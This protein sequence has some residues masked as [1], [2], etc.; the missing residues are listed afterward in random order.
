MLVASCKMVIHTKSLFCSV[1]KALRADCVCDIGSRDGDQALLFRHLL[2]AA[3]IMAFEA[4]PINFQTMSAKAVLN[5]NLIEIFPYAV[6]SQKGHAGFYVTDV[7]YSNPEEN[8]GTSSLLV[9]E[10][11]KVRQTVKVETVRIDEFILDH[12]PSAKQIGLW[13]DVEGAEYEVLSGMAGIKDRVVALHVETA[14]TPMRVGQKTYS[15]LVPLLASMGFVPS[16]S[17]MRRK[18]IW[19]DAVFL[20]RHAI[21]TLGNRLA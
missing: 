5:E 13:L 18:S 6:T 12:H 8:I 21:D 3:K 2:P 10:G 19:G 17:N 4:N 1:L 9:H 15:E 20:S 16:G 11:L 7:D 14:R